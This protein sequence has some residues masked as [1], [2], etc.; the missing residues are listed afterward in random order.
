[1]RRRG[2]KLLELNLNSEPNF[3]GD[4]EVVETVVDPPTL[5][6]LI[7]PSSSLSTSGEHPG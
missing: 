4:V 3:S 2:G 1:M 5:T 7:E 6:L